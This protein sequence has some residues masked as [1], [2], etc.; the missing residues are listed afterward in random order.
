MWA[1]TILLTQVVTASRHGPEFTGRFEANHLLHG[2]IA[3]LSAE[4]LL[5]TRITGQG[6]WELLYT[7]DRCKKQPD[8]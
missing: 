2:A 5:D 1:L 6:R 3:G 4:D 8:R 7:K